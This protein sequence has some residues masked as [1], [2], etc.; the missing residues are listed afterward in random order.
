MFEHAANWSGSLFKSMWP[1][2]WRATKSRTW[3]G[4]ELNQINLKVEFGVNPLL[5]DNRAALR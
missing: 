4:M 5:D 3:T 2:G 1:T